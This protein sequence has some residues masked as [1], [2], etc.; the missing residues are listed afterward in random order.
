MASSTESTCQDSLLLL[1]A[2]ALNTVC[3]KGGTG[4]NPQAGLV[5]KVYYNLLCG[6]SLLAD[7]VSGFLSPSP[8]GMAQN[9]S[10][11]AQIHSWMKKVDYSTVPPSAN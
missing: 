5:R 7:A 2:A 6:S 4:R 1:D 11:L 9:L 8:S 3:E 10:I